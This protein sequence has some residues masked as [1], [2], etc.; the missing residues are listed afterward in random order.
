MKRKILSKPA[1]TGRLEGPPSEETKHHKTIE[2]VDKTWLSAQ[3]MIMEIAPTLFHLLDEIES[4]PQ[5]PANDPIIR[6]ASAAIFQWAR[7]YNLITRRRRHNVLNC[8]ASCSE[9]LLNI[10][11]YFFLEKR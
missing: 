11:E 8:T 4:I 5:K 10:P 9:Y 7:A 1:G 2:A 6:A 3:F